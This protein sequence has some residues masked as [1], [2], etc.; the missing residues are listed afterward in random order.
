MNVLWRKEI[1]KDI[2]TEQHIEL[3]DI[4]APVLMKDAKPLEEACKEYQDYDIFCKKEEK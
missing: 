3:R 2:T 1:T 4:K